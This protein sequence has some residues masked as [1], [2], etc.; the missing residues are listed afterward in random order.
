M[1]Q[2][3]VI[4][5]LLAAASARAEENKDVARAYFQAGVV[6]YDQGKYER[7]LNEFQRAQALSHNAELYFN[8]AACEE[9]MDHYQAAA[10]LL[11]QYILEKPN[12]P[13]RS[14]VESRV[15]AL[16]E[17][18]E[19]LHRP[20][21]EITP[22]PVQPPPAQP[23]PPPPSAPGQPI[24]GFVALGVTAALGVAAIGLGSYT[25][26]HHGD[27][28]SG[29][30]ATVTG[31][32]SSDISGLHG[33]AIGTDVL[34]GLTAAAAVA[35]VVVFVLERGHKPPAHAARAGLVF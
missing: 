3:L 29:C 35:T 11:K 26:V 2:L 22:L 20:D 12:A 34:I 24:G 19:R 14:N 33:T 4:C 15:K 7:A 21:G 16:E 13:D 31:C 25:V 28:K 6:F 18:D 23:A 1:R 9:H 17:R 30:G 10:L 8:M 32:S 5:A 27:L